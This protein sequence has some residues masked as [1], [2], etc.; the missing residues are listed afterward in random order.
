MAKTLIQARMIHETYVL[1]CQRICQK[2]RLHQEKL[3]AIFGNSPFGAVKIEESLEVVDRIHAY[4]CHGGYKLTWAA[5]KK[6]GLWN[7]GR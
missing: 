4:G 5:V 7:H 1:I 2:F 6:R 3:Y